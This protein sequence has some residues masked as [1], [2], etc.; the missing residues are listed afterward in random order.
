MVDFYR[1]ELIERV[2]RYSDQ[3]AGGMPNLA[4]VGCAQDVQ[5]AVDEFKTA[6][7]GATWRQIFAAVPSHYESAKNMY[8]ALRSNA[9]RLA[10]RKRIKE[11]KH[12]A[13]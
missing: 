3:T 8:S 6:N 4:G 7:P 12:Q 5:R 11:R 9:V 10:I 2:E 1:R 13:A